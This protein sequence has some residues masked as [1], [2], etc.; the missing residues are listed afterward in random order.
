MADHRIAWLPISD[1]RKRY[2]GRMHWQ[3]TD[4]LSPFL[5]LLNRSRGHTDTPALHQ[6]RLWANKGRKP[7]WPL[8][9]FSFQLSPRPSHLGSGK[10]MPWPCPV[11]VDSLIHFLQDARLYVSSSL[12]IKALFPLSNNGL[13]RNSR[14]G[15]LWR[16]TNSLCTLLEES[17]FKIHK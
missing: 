11:L 13:T 7:P 16:D 1:R 4:G 2:N 5:W 8:F 9:L 12:R 3:Q 15:H 14:L 10:T 6:K 17:V